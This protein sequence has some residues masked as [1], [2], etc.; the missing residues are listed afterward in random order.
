MNT[1]CHIGTSGWVYPHWR[2]VFYPQDLPQS[3][4]FDYYSQHFATVEINSS[5]YRLPAE[6]TFDRWQAQ[7]HQDS[8]TPSRPTAS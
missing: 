1:H 4:W 3:R 6:T 7:A 2:G 8:S 5:F